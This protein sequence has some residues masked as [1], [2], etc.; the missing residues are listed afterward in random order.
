[1]ILSHHTFP[2]RHHVM[3]AV[4][5]QAGAFVRAFCRS[6]ILPHNRAEI[7]PIF[8]YVRPRR[9]FSFPE[10]ITVHFTASFGGTVN[11]SKH[12]VNKSKKTASFHLH[13]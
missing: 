3:F 4:R 6:L 5:M 13:K 2:A 1:M 10:H 9:S 12:F 8:N 7:N 11:K